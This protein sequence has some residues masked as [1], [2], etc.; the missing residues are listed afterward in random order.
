MYNEEANVEEL[1]RQIAGTLEGRCSWELILVDDGSN[2]DTVPHA[3]EALQRLGRGHVLRLARRYGQS[4]AMQAGFD[5]ARGRTVVSLD[6]D[7][8]NDPADI[9]MLIAALGDEFDIAVG[10]RSKR[11]DHV[12]RKIPSWVANRIIRLMTGVP[13]RDNGCSLKAYRGS[14]LR[15]VRL[16]SDMHRFIPALAVGVAGARVVEVPVNHRARVAGTSKYGMSRVFLVAA[17]LLTLKMVHSFRLSP[18]TMFGF[19]A[20]VAVALGLASGAASVVAWFTFHPYKAAGYVLPGV[21]LLWLSLG[22]FLLSAGV[23]AQ[24]IVQVRDRPPESRGACP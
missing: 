14:L 5:H 10:Y 6:G 2:D 1:V 24:A 3:R 7:L 22:G 20:C 18:L 23:L 11:Q 16:Y 9:P 19:G 13:I 4:T 15:R 8:Q 12:V 21:A 17:D